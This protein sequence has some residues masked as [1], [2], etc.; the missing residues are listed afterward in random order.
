M[1]IVY[2]FQNWMLFI[3]W[4][5]KWKIGHKK[6]NIFHLNWYLLI[7]CNYKFIFPLKIIDSQKFSEQ[8]PKTNVCAGEKI[9]LKKEGG[10]EIFSEK[11]YTPEEI[12]LSL[13]MGIGHLS[14]I[15]FSGNIF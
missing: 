3:I 5:K 1:K 10:E 15:V 11:I 13:L 7:F 14:S 4:G 9:D 12:I 2:I 6:E 8:N